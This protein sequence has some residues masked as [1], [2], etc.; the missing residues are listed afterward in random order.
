[1]S[2]TIEALIVIGIFALVWGWIIYEMYNAPT[3]DKDGNIISN[4]RQPNGF[5]DEKEDVK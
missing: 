5:G 3:V 2:I 1:M 4:S